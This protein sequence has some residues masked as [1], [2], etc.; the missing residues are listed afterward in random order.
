[1][2]PSYLINMVE[3]TERLH[4]S[5]AQLLGLGIIF[6]RIN[7]VDGRTLSEKEI[8]DV[9]DAKTNKYHARN[10]LLASEIG[11][12]LSHIEVWKKIVQ[13]NHKGGFVFE[14]DFQASD[15]LG[16]L[17]ELLSEDFG[18]WDMVKLFTMNADPKCIAR[19]PLGSDHI[20]ATPYKVPNC[21]IGY[22]LRKSA[23][24]RLLDCSLPFFRPIDEDHKF[25][26]EKGLRIALVLPP[27]LTIGEQQTTTGTITDE[28]RAAKPAEFTGRI[29]LGFRNLV[30]QIRYKILLYWHRS[31]R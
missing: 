25:F 27:P 14:D 23:A 11:C 17:M 16:T 8:N 19:R 13:G 4:K 6:E 29:L 18:N 20:I 5:K 12:Y 28:R 24:Q 10:P 22:G 31:K 26:W 3:N 1:M 7:A 15:D 2:W 9:Y 21:T 30:Y